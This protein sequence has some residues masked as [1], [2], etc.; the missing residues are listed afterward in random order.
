MVNNPHQFNQSL[1]KGLSILEFIAANNG[2]A[3]LTIIANSLGMDKA[4]AKRFLN[5]LV[6]LGYIASSQHGKTFSTTLKAMQIS[7]SAVSHLGWREI[8]RFYLEQLFA[9]LRETIS[10][11]MLDG[12]EIL[13]LLRLNRENFGVQDVGIGSRRAAYASSMGKMLLALEP[14]ERVRELVGLMHF[15]PLTLHTVASPEA[16]LAQL[17]EARRNGYAVSNQEVSELTRSISTPIMSGEKAV[18]ALAIAVRA[19]DYTREDMIRL[20]VPKALSCAAQ[21]TTAL[22]Q[23]EYRSAP[24]LGN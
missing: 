10:L 22:K 17:E 6:E 12:T 4:T 16:L 11:S 24:G 19:D 3:T 23:V 1:A 5:T 13:Y 20:M 21:I 7:Y 15:R 9:E 18:A 2:E 8:A 14:E